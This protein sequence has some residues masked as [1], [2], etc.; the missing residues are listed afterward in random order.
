M[1]VCGRVVLWQEQ[2]ELKLKEERR[3]K[4]A[5]E[6][7]KR[8]LAYMK[9][10]DKQ[11]EARVAVR[12]THHPQT[13]PPEPH[14]TLCC[15]WRHQ[16]FKEFQE[17][18][19]RKHELD[20][21]TTSRAKALEDLVNRRVEQAQKRD[22]EERRRAKETAAARKK[23]AVDDQLR[24]LAQQIAEKEEAKKRLREEARAEMQATEQRILESKRLV[25]LVVAAAWACL[26]RSVGTV[27]TGVV[28]CHVGSYCVVLCRVWY[29]GYLPQ[30]EEEKR[31]AK[32]R[33]LKYKKDLEAQIRSNAQTPVDPYFHM[34]NTERMVC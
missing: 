22:E 26:A 7:Y 15:G 30:E 23:K 9:H 29:G 6:D 1:C 12:T 18:T 14:P 8:M 16:Y 5:D 20:L 28:S 21:D 33:H 27:V 34:S 32:Q 10:M 24:V 11:E 3:K 2:A 17:K 25:R 31:K 4:E 19:K 13:R